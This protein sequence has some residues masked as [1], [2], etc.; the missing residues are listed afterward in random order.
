MAKEPDLI[1]DTVNAHSGRPAVELQHNQNSVDKSRGKIPTSWVILL[2]LALCACTGKPATPYLAPTV[3]APDPLLP[4]LAPTTQVIL[5]ENNQSRV[6]PTPDCTPSLTF[7]ED[8][9]V[10]DGSVVTP[11]EQIDKRW[12][13]ENSGTCNWDASY[14][15]RLVAGPDLDA[16]A[17]QALYPA[18][19]GTQ[20]EIRILFIAPGEAGIYNSAWQA[21][22]P[23]DSPF[24]DPFFIEITVVEP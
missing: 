16:K 4:S 18:R 6:N 14:R 20:A 2:A 10:P 1:W 22:S 21:Y 19:S 11:G 17:V 3:A 7:L 13:V 15:L 8:L 9:T 5:V 24:G 12:L 23:Q